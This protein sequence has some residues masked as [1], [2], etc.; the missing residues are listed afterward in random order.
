MSARSTLMSPTIAT[1]HS[2][3]FKV[4]AEPDDGQTFCSVG[5]L[6]HLGNVVGGRPPDSN[7]ARRLV[8]RQ[9]VARRSLRLWAF[10]RCAHYCS[11]LPTTP[12]NSLTQGRQR[13]RQVPSSSHPNTHSNAHRY[14]STEPN[15]GEAQHNFR[16]G[17]ETKPPRRRRVSGDAEVVAGA[18]RHATCPTE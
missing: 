18:H 2:T 3:R 15:F 8:D 10:L 1:E 16:R 4:L 17:A 14:T 6:E 12:A 11:C 13:S 9:E 5:G 7:N